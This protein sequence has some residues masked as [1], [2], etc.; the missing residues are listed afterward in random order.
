MIQVARDVICGSY[1]N[2][3][4]LTTLVGRL[5]YNIFR[6]IKKRVA[7]NQQLEEQVSIIGR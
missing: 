5:K 3:L 1:E 6:W 4:G 2:Y 7:K